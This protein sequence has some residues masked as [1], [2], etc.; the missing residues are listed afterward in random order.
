MILFWLNN[1]YIDI[2]KEMCQ[3]VKWL[4]LSV[5]FRWLFSFYL[6]RFSNIYNEYVLLCIACD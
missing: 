1:K 3:I 6:Y 5:I 4:F 2:W